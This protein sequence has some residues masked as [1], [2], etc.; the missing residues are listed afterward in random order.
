MKQIAVV[1][2]VIQNYAITSVLISFVILTQCH[3]QQL[4]CTADIGMAENA[5]EDACAAV[6]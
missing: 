1:L 3:I 5:A 4:M 6:T 2:I